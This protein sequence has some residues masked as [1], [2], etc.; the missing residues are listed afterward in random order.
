MARIEGVPAARAGLFVRLA[1]WFTK[2]RYGRVPGPA[3]VIAHH[4]AILSAAGAYE[5]VF[6]RARLVDKR[7][8]QLASLKAAALI[9][10]VF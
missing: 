2:R 6:E 10:C 1:Y 7:L 5:L 8:K 3:T 4:P 9:G